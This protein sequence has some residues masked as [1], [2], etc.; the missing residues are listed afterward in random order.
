M[1]RA[2]LARSPGENASGVE[3]RVKLREFVLLDKGITTPE[4]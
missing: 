2:Y 4:T 1:R 3:H